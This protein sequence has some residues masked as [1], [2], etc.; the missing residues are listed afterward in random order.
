MALSL[1]SLKHELL[2]RYQLSQKQDKWI[3]PCNRQ[4]QGAELILEWLKKEGGGAVWLATS[5]FILIPAC[6]LAGAGS[7]SLV[8]D[9]R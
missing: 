3:S 8:V 5:A 2:Q 9:C 4:L 1:R 6:L 7:L